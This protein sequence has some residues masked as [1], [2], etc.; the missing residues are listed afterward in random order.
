M[1]MESY[2]KSDYN[3]VVRGPARAKYDVATVYEIID[4]HFLCHVAYVYEGTA[5]AI[6]T[7][8]GRVGETIYLHGAMGNRM[9]KSLLAQEKVSL[10]IT[11]MDGLVLARSVFHH[12]F[13]YRSVVV[14]GSPRLIEDGAEK[15]EA[16][17]IITE[18]IIPGRWEE[19]RVPNEVEL[20]RTRVIAVDIEDASAKIRAEGVND[21]PEDFDLDVWAGVIP[22]KVVKGT[23]LPEPDLKHGVEVSPSVLNYHI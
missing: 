12:S 15:D 1:K 20:K 23:P 10:T 19:A 13:N 5:I 6:P 2:D 18:N 22:L 9:L 16:L 4:S 3:K 14:F 7:G 8:Y 11:H 21:E 17:R